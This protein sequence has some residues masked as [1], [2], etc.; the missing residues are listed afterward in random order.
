MR[1]GQRVFT[2]GVDCKVGRVL[3]FSFELEWV[4]CASKQIGFFL[5]LSIQPTAFQKKALW[6]AITALSLTVTGAIAIGLIYECTQVLA[7]M[8]PFLVPFAIAGVLAYLLEPGVVWLERRGLTRYRAVLLVFAAFFLGFGGLGWWMVAKVG[9]QT[10]NLDTKLVGYAEKARISVLRFAD[11]MD[12]KFG[13]DLVSMLPV[14]PEVSGLSEV[15]VVE[16]KPAEG[17]VVKE[18][19]GGVVEEVLAGDPGD[20]GMTLKDFLS[21]NW[22]KQALPVVV[23]SVWKTIRSSVGG[24]LGVF[25]FLLSMVIIPLYLFYFLIESAKIKATWANYLP[26]RASAFKDEVVDCLMEINGY[27]VAFFRGQ[28]FVSVLNG[29]TTGL[30]LMIVGLDFGLMIGLLLCVLGI[31]PYLGIAIC[32]IPAVVIAAVQ[33]GSALVPG[34]PWWMLPLVVTIIFAVV[35][36]IDGLFI[37]PRVV[38]ESVGLHPMTVIVSVLVWSLLLGGLLGAILAVPLTASVKVLFQRYVWLAKLAPQT[39]GGAR[40]GQGLD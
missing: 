11:E 8:Q 22:V 5:I 27:L 14:A 34:D 39:V 6:A 31:I 30:G 18:E 26:L 10:G 37:T 12:A 28:L 40:Q 29:I 16:K 36:Q 7:F 2:R 20:G 35:Q 23:T 24:V 19:V 4:G 25:G 13:I 15:K 3:E 21:G 9:S 32:W 1:E 38:G 17:D 33:G